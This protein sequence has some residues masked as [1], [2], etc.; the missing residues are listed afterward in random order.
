MASFIISGHTVIVDD[1]DAHLL[2]SGS[3]RVIDKPRNRY[4]KKSVRN[5]DKVETVYLH[6][7]IMGA[8]K[9]ELVDHINGDS[10]DNRRANMRF[11]SLTDNARNRS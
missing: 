1:E 6:R 2:A 10:L 8:A 4:V 11:S 9:G 5:G 7:L 3:W